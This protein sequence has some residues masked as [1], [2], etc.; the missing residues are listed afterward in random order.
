MLKLNGKES[1]AASFTKFTAH[2]FRK[3]L[4]THSPKLHH[5]LSTSAGSIAQAHTYLDGQGFNRYFLLESDTSVSGLHQTGFQAIFNGYLEEMDVRVDGNTLGVFRTN[6]ADTYNTLVLGKDAN[7][8]FEHTN[9]FLTVHGGTCLV[10]NVILSAASVSGNGNWT[11]NYLNASIDATIAGVLYAHV[12]INAKDLGQITELDNLR[13]YTSADYYV[14]PNFIQGLSARGVSIFDGALN[15]SGAS[16]FSNNIYSYGPSSFYGNVYNSGIVTNYS[17]V[18]GVGSQWSTILATDSILSQNQISADGG[19]WES[20]RTTRMG[21]W[22][23]YTPTITVNTGTIS[24]TPVNQA[25]SAVQGKTLHV[26]FRTQVT[27]SVAAKI[28]KVSLPGTMVASSSNLNMIYQGSCNVSLGSIVYGAWC[29]IN[30]GESVIQIYQ[31]GDVSTV[32]YPTGTTIELQ[33][34]ISFPIA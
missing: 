7:T 21:Y 10:G 33:G 5:Y 13:V 32:N 11:A 15:V 2:Q 24:T 34:H 1:P 28:I 26:S 27:L 31:L 25:T 16:T 8:K 20:Q 6:D 4:I 22:T 14:K 12:G 17:T 3:H 29:F 30:P 9:R 23:N 19:Y 18:L